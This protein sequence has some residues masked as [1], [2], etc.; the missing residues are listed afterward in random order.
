MTPLTKAELEE[1]IICGVS[2]T[3]LLPQNPAG[4][5]NLGHFSLTVEVPKN[6]LSTRQL[7]ARIASFYQAG[8]SI[9]SP[10]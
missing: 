3:V 8:P 5:L 2:L 7:L 10:F 9:Q 1:I 4:D 6:G